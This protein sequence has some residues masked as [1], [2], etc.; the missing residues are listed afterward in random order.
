MISA[1]PTYGKRVFFFY[2][3]NGVMKVVHTSEPTIY[4]TKTGKNEFNIFS[5]NIVSQRQYIPFG[6]EAK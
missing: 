2:W 1:L 6:T 4:L 3:C 5:F